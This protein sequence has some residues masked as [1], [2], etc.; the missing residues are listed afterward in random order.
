MQQNLLASLVLKCSPLSTFI[1][2]FVLSP[3]TNENM[4]IGSHSV[5]VSMGT[6]PMILNSGVGPLGLSKN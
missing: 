2:S 6:E 4:T 3:R 1:R 5:P